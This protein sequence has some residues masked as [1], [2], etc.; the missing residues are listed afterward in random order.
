MY[1][2]DVCVRIRTSLLGPRTER[3]EN[4]FQAFRLSETD[5]CLTTSSHKNNTSSNPIEHSFH[6][7]IAGVDA[8]VLAGRIVVA[9]GTGNVVQDSA[10]VEKQHVVR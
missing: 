5:R 10:Y 2:Q 6:V 8:V 7:P 9:H 4:V 1:E 3:G